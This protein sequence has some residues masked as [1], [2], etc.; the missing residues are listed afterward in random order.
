VRLK[1]DFQEELGRVRFSDREIRIIRSLLLGFKKNA[2]SWRVSTAFSA[3]PD[4]NTFVRL[5]NTRAVQVQ[6]LKTQQLKGK[7]L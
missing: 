6:T 7:R 3:L 4:R 1:R 5:S 2:E